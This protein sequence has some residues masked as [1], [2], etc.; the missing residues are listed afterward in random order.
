MIEILVG[1]PNDDK[2][3]QMWVSVGDVL[4]LRPAS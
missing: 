3:F 4:Y 2:S 1:I